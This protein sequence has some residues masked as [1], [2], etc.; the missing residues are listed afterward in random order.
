M[1]FAVGRKREPGETPPVW[2]T[3][4]AAIVFEDQAITYQ[5][6]GQRCQMIATWLKEQGV[7]MG[8]RVAFWGVCC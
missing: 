1:P 2:E 7:V 8:D 3:W 4:L 6:F 5:E